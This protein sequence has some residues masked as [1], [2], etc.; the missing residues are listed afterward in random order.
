MRRSAT[1]VLCAVLALLAVLAIAGQGSPVF[2]GL[3]WTPPWAV[4]QPLP[5]ERSHPP[6]TDTPAPRRPDRI[7]D[8]DVSWLVVAI[9]VI[10]L[11]V[12]AG[13]VWRAIRRRLDVPE[14]DAT[15]PL[16][17]LDGDDEPSVEQ[18]DPAPVRR[19]LD[20]ALDALSEPREPR[21]AI[22]RA[23]LGLEEGAADSGVRRMPAETP[24]EFVARVVARVSAD[25]DAARTLL[26]LYLT[27]RFGSAPVTGE[28]VA[29][30]RDAL[31]AL[32]T[33]WAAPS[34]TGGV[35]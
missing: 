14:R 27:V 30:A 24:G 16:G 5:S 21:D 13:L 29:S 17:S 9:A 20:R 31:R 32:Q 22:E 25:R 23:W 26:E 1:V 12:V 10:V 33:S 28:H 11:V 8:I 34:A 4:T 6:V 7:V 35:R 19:G 15:V 3:R 18:P 2:T